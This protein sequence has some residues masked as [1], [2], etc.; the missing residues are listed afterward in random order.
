MQPFEMIRKRDGRLVPFDPRRIENAVAKAFAATGEASPEAAATVTQQVLARL[1]QINPAIPAVEQ[2]QDLVEEALMALGWWRTARAYIVYREQHRALREMKAQVSSSLVEDYLSQV[3]WRVLENANSSFSLQGLNSYIVGAVAAHY[4][5]EKVYPAEVRQAHREGDFHLHDLGT[6]GPY[7]VGWDL[8]ALLNEGFNGVP[9]QVE[10]APPKHFRS[11]LGQLYNFLYTLQGEAAGAQAVAN[12][13]TLL[14]PYIRLDGLTYPQ[15]RQAVQEFVFNLNVPTRV[16]F[17]TPFTNVTLDFRVP[18]YMRG[19]PAEAA[20]RVWPFTYGDLEEEV[21]L[22]NRA[23][24]E[25]L[26]EGDASGKGF[27]FPV[28]TYNVG[29][30]FPWDAPEAGLLFRVAAK[31]GSPYFANF[32]NSGMQPE[33]VRSMC[34]RLRLDTSQLL[35]RGGGLFGAN[36]LTGSIGVVTLNLARL[37]YLARD[38]EDLFLRLGHL[39]SLAVSALEVK[40]KALERFTE[41]GLYPYSARYLAGVKRRTGR[42]WSQHFATIGVVGGHE[43][44]LNF[45]GV[46]LA[47]PQGRALALKVLDFL[48][49]C[50][51]RAQEETGN[52]YNLE[53]TPAEGCAFRLARMDK[54]RFPEA[55]VANEAAWQNGAAP[56]YTNSTMLPVD[57]TDDIFAVLDHQDE[58]QTKYT[59]G[60]V[61]HVWIGEEN[62]DPGACADL[63]RRVFAHYRLPYLSLT[64]TYAVCPAHGYLSGRQEVCPRCGAACEVYS[65]VVG[66]YRPVSRWNAGKKAEFADRRVFHIGAGS[67]FGR[68]PGGREI[69]VMEKTM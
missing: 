36:P 67:A 16:G 18:A 42:W 54:E 13:D 56:Y 3:D 25:V 47:H 32:V 43:M 9:G 31:Y 37:G 55:R 12:F 4:W 66:Y 60:T 34:C 48:R 24:L 14:A 5:L 64:P 27:T 41:A 21:A 17:Q 52:L 46:G 68:L 40:R 44:C 49:A 19:E 51:R 22:L 35:R 57:A 15:V 59:G 33:E 62:P 23:F 7:C 26:L 6:L 39:F 8:A 28:P 10:A 65:R 2:V 20:G 50:C 38:E 45:L 69:A 30:D 29:P 61:V 53:A 1:A 58:L 63:V 11:A